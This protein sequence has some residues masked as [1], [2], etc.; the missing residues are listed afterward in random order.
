MWTPTL[1]RS[2]N[3]TCRWY[4]RFLPWLHAAKEHE[5]ASSGSD[6][7]YVTYDDLAGHTPG[8]HLFT[9]A[10]GRTEWRETE[11]ITAK[12][13]SYGD[14]YAFPGG[15]DPTDWS[16]TADDP[17]SWQPSNS[18]QLHRSEVTRMVDTMHQHGLL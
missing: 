16:Y 4:C 8:W 1:D 9:D 10:Q 11:R 5:Y 12:V 2:S 14:L 15:Y 13:E 3:H 18:G 7:Q 17:V 6:C